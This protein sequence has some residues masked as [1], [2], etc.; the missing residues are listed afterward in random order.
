[1][2]SSSAPPKDKRILALC[3]KWEFNGWDWRL[4][5]EGVWREVYFYQGEWRMWCGK[6]GTFTTASVEF[7]HWTDTPT[8]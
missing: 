8:C 7:D 3:K 4:M 2:I 6:Y 5:P 1:M